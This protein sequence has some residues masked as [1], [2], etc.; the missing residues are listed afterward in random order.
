[1]PSVSSWICSIGR[2]DTYH[3]PPKCRGNAHLPCRLHDLLDRF[4]K[5]HRFINRLPSLVF[6]EQSTAFT[7]SMFKGLS[8]AEAPVSSRAT[9]V[10]MFE[11]RMICCQLDA[12]VEVEV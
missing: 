6:V 1:M 3:L 12:G 8:S 5:R 9:A 10:A 4:D 11:T 2:L 7:T